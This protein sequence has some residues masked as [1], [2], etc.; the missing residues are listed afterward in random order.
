MLYLLDTNVLIDAN[1]D[2]YPL[3]RIPEFW[4]W[5]VHNGR[6][7]RVKIA[8][9]VYE[10]ITDGKDDLA[11]W[12]RESEV[13]EAL[14]LNEEADPSIVAFVINDGYAADLTDD[15]VAKLG[16]DPFLMAYALVAPRA[17]SVVTTESV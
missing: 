9:E 17:R 7:G 12:G 1:R 4:E 16:R 10:E 2:Y 11:K 15:E 8:M 14:L 5:L 6:E 3:T 13:K